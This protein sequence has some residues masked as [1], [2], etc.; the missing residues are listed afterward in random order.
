MSEYAPGGRRSPTTPLDLGYDTAQLRQIIRTELTGLALHSGLSGLT[1]G[2]DHTQYQKE[3][4]KGVA[5]GY[6][7]LNSSGKVPIA[8][9]PTGLP[10]TFSGARAYN[11]GNIGSIT[12]STAFPLT[13][14]SERY[15][16]DDYH[17]TSSNTSRLTAP[18]TGYYHFGGCVDW[19]VNGS[20]NQ[21]SVFLRIN[22]TTVVASNVQLPSA[23]YS[24]QQLVVCDYLF[25]AG[26]YVELCVFQDSGSDRQ[27]DAVANRSP[28]F[29]MHLIGE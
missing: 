7:E 16:T 8:Q 21:R 27:I 23:S 2:D 29:W 9:L 28:E 1:T 22:G 6:A 12:T 25:T 11:S 17:S 20:G 5:N 10:T 3:S 24:V 18:V 26:D 14:D 4:E 19:D 15:D 13:L